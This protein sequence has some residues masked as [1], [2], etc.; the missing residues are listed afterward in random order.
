MGE[1][2]FVLVHE[3]LLQKV[4]VL[5]LETER[6]NFNEA[7][8]K[9]DQYTQNSSLFL[10]QENPQRFSQDGKTRHVQAQVM[11]TFLFWFMSVRI[12]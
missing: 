8:L 12:P 10:L 7:A 2:V 5:F 9:V 1:T 6:E 3:G 11:K 4:P